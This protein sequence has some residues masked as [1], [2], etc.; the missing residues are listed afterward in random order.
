MLKKVVDIS[1]CQTDNRRPRFNIRFRRVAAHVALVFGLTLASGSLANAAPN[2]ALDLSAY[3]GKVVYLDFWASWCG[4]CKQSF[5]YMMSLNRRYGASGLVVVAVNV[6]KDEAKAQAF[7]RKMGANFRVVYDSK[8]VL[9]S[10]YKIKAMPTSIL[11]GRD[12]QVR[13]VHKGFHENQEESYDEQI[14][15]LLN[16]K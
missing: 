4:P 12:G 6:D 14:A 13:Y 9:P 3:K 11:I 10:E 5:P 1:S 7:L 16:E 2:P 15:E 8:G